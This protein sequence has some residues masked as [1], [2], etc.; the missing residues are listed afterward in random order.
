MRSEF[1]NDTRIELINEFQRLD[2][3]EM[4][5]PRFP[6]SATG[7]TFAWPIVRN[8]R[9]FIGSQIPYFGQ[10]LDPSKPPMA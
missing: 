6:G 5:R 10:W 3:P 8:E 1:D 7:V 4:Y 2:A 9:V